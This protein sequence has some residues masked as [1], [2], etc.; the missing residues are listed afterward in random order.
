MTSLQ[1]G[2]ILEVTAEKLAVGGHAVC[3][4]QGMVVFVPFAAP[5]DRLRVEVTEVDKR[6]AKG[7][8]QEILQPSPHRRPARCRHF[9]DCGGCQFQHIDYAEQT[10]QKGEFVRDAL[11]RI[12]G[13]DWQRP[14]PVHAGPEW[15]YRSRTAL[16]VW[17]HKLG[18]HRAFS[19]ETV[20]AEECPVLVPELERALP[21]VRAALGRVPRDQEPHQIDG[22]CGVGEPVFAPD[23]PGMRKDLVEH[24]VLGFSFLIEPESFF[25]Q[26][27]HLTPDLVQHAIDGL[28]GGLCYDL[29]AGVGLFSLPLSRQCGR[30]V[31]VEDERRAVLLGRVNA[32]NAGADQVE[33]VRLSV[34]AF[35]GQRELER[36]DVVVMDPPRLGAKPAIPGL[37]A[38][39]PERLVYVSCDPGTL[40]RDLKDLC[41]GGYRLDAVAA[42]DMFP[43]T[44]HVEA[45]AKL[46]LGGTRS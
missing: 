20:D 2:Q 12:G 26:N 45:V 32:R 40:A 16:K 9:G 31:A 28:D 4:H 8:I 19:N 42:F 33:Y 21:A 25:Q 17:R 7:R 41:G 1:P 46:A 36:P 30:V 22:A 13:I 3:R 5:G 29:Y 18:F 11:R 23:L 14:I 27:R 10:A 38:L 35:L 15:G 37:L 34:E 24:Q 43:Q 6:F 39:R 44:W